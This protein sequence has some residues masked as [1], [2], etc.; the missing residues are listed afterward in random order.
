MS[1]PTEPK[2]SPDGQL[3]KRRYM[4]QILIAGVWCFLDYHDTV[5]QARKRIAKLATKGRVVRVQMEVVLPHE[6]R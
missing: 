1:S 3:K 4:S 2:S 6:V 5:K